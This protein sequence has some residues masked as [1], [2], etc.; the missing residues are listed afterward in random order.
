MPPSAAPTARAWAAFGMS[1]ETPAF[2]PRA[3]QALYA[4]EYPGNVRELEH[5]VERACLLA[6][7]PELD[8]DLLPIELAG[9]SPAA[10]DW[11]DRELTN[12][13]LKEAVRQARD[14]AAIEVEQRFVRAL[15][16]QAGGNVS[17]ASRTSGISRT[18]LQKLL[19]RLRRA[20]RL[21]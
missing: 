2:T 21:P 14:R 17:K 10:T 7:G 4:Y 12:A 3:E 5:I 8:L 1:T 13:S 6:T 16:D 15:L 18:R 9:A 11:S 20:L 19:A